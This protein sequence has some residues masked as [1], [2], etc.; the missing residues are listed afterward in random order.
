MLILY[1]I[2]TGVASTFSAI[3]TLPGDCVNATNVNNVQE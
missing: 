3:D 1:L 2:Y